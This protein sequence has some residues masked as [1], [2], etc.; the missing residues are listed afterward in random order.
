MTEVASA[1]AQDAHLPQ[2]KTR[3]VRIS[4]IATKT[5][6]FEAALG[7]VALLAGWLTGCWPLETLHTDWPSLAMAAFG[8]V[9][10]AGG[11]VALLPLF[12]RVSWAPVR[13]LRIIMQRMV[14]PLFRDANI[15]QL[16]IIS[17][18]AGVGEELFFRGWLQAWLG[19]MFS[20]VGGPWTGLILAS[21]AFG[22]AHCLTWEYAIVAFGM[23]LVLGGL[24][25]VTDNL[26]AP[27]LAHT[28][29]DFAALIYWRA[30]V[31]TPTAPT[32]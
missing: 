14:A 9:A 19:Q 26:L 13:R 12:F 6:I 15:A 11:A 21:I 25:L 1:P 32:L 23:G 22:V 16:A 18:A 24:S 17:I 10:V 27:I 7:L 3:T 4:Y 30:K 8:G 29:Y 31:A 20:G 28:L 2:E 5:L